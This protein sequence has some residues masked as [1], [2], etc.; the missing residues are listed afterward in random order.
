MLLSDR[1]GKGASLLCFRSIY[2]KHLLKM[3]LKGFRPSFS[4]G[5]LFPIEVWLSLFGGSALLLFLVY[6]NNKGFSF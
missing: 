6:R 5:K 4:D 2:D 3:R 1:T